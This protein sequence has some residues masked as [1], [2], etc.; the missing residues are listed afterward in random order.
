[1]DRENML[2]DRFWYRVL[3]EL[4]NITCTFSYVARMQWN[5]MAFKQSRIQKYSLVQP[6]KLNNVRTVCLG[7]LKGFLPLCWCGWG[8]C[9]FLYE[10]GFLRD[11]VGDATND[12][13]GDTKLLVD[14]LIGFSL[15]PEEGQEKQNSMMQT[16]LSNILMSS[17]KSFFFLVCNIYYMKAEVKEVLIYVIATES[18]SHLSHDTW[19]QLLPSHF[20]YFDYCYQKWV[21]NRSLT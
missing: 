13:I 6:L 21:F 20:K 10:S 19:M 9:V 12:G 2:A 3:V 7:Q 1:M 11:H 14:Q 18:W 15:V 16:V 4:I 17:N 5:N 8:I